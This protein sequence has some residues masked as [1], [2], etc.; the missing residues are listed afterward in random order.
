[1]ADKARISE[2]VWNTQDSK[3][4]VEVGKDVSVSDLLHGII[5]QSG[6]DAS[7]ALAEHIAGTEESFST[8]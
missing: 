6:N 3:T 1:M 2:K 4:F 7:V 5:T 8:S